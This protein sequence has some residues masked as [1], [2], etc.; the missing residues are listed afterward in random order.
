MVASAMRRILLILIACLSDSAFSHPADISHLRI[1]VAPQRIEFRYSLNIATLAR[2]ARI[3]ANGDNQVTFAEIKAL[4]PAV[5]TFLTAS[6]RVAI[7]DSPSSLG[8]FESYECIWPSA[9][10][11]VLTPHDA[12]QRFVDYRFVQAPTPLLETLQ[13][14]FEGF[15]S[16]GEL[17]SIEAVFD[18]SGEPATTVTF[19]QTEPSFIYDTGWR[20]PP[21][22]VATTQQRFSPNM[23]IW[24]SVVALTG[25]GLWTLRKRQT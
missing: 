13:L 4:A 10:T 23:L 6:S 7:N 21:S 11:T 19:S 2:I 5:S 12:D 15:Q 16:L 3:D 8:N 20:S 1:H 14:Q 22:A 17:H 9:D 25:I 24:T 18:Q